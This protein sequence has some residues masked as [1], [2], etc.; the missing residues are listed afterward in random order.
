MGRREEDGNGDEAVEGCV[1][2]SS[3]H[4]TFV[5]GVAL[6][7]VR[8]LGRRLDAGADGRRAAYI[9]RATV[10]GEI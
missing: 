7:H 2:V 3:G 5:V 6:S 1:C 9:H 4:C 8:S 10:C